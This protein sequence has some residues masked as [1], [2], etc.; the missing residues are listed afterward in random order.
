MNFLPDPWCVWW[1]ASNTCIC[2][3]HLVKSSLPVT[4]IIPYYVSVYKCTQIRDTCGYWLSAIVDIGYQRLWIL[5]IIDCGYWLSAIVDIGYQRLWILVISDCGYWSS[6]IVDIGYQRLWILVISNCGY[7]L[8]V[9]VD[10][11]YQ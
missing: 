4:T 5:V 10:I 3:S 11:S 2:L 6:A 7:W 9:I 8:S 1:C